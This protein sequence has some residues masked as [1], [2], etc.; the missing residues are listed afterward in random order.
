MWLRRSFV[1]WLSTVVQQLKINNCFITYHDFMGQ[2]FGKAML[3]GSSVLYGANE[4]HLTVLIGECL[5][6][7]VQDGFICIPPDLARITG[8]IHLPEV[9][10]W[11][12]IHDSC[13]IVAEKIGVL[14]WWLRA[15]K[16]IFSMSETKLVSLVES[17]LTSHIMLLF[18]YSTRHIIH[19]SS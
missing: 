7:N 18:L 9:V 4:G 13:N 5:I 12:S 10:S 15:S 2:K 19:K 11:R 3:A 1:L 6:W 16:C 14:I 8:R 17:I